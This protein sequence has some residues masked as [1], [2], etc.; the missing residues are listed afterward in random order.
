[1]TRGQGA[2]PIGG[3][4]AKRLVSDLRKELLHCS[5]GAFFGAEVDLLERFNVSRPTLRQAA[6][7]LE[8]DNLLSVRRG[9]RGGYFVRRP[10][11]QSV[12]N[13]ASLYL[14][15]RA[16]RLNDLIVAAR[17]PISTLLRLAAESCDEDARAALRQAFDAYVSTDFPALPVAKFLTAERNMVA[18]YSRL[19][20]NPPLTLVIQIFQ[21]CGARVVADNV[22]DGRPDRVQACAKLRA[23]QVEAVLEGDGRL[24]VLF[25]LR[26]SELRLSY[27]ELDDPQATGRHVDLSS[28]I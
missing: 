1:M 15:G 24:A 28:L 7:V 8:R 12:V 20:S 6:R 2:K 27:L 11:V 25:D 3:V 18:L 16:A 19:A 23:R 14:N 5:E 17:G 26:A 13:A 21:A 4:S 22:F 10:D 9:P